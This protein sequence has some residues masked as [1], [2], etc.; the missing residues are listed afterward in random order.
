M[1]SGLIEVAGNERDHVDVDIDIVF[2]FVCFRGNIL[3]Q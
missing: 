3:F 1:N 2:I